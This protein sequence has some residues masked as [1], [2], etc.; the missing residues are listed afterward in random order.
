MS[1]PGDWRESGSVDGAVCEDRIKDGDH[2]RHL[3]IQVFLADVLNA[4]LTAPSCPLGLSDLRVPDYGLGN[5]SQFDF[6]VPG[7]CS[8][9]FQEDVVVDTVLGGELD[10]V[11]V[12][13]HLVLVVPLSRI[14]TPFSATVV[15]GA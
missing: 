9:G 10:D 2:L 5:G 13:R 6:A 14:V 7:D 15:S 1:R 8:R 3:V 11:D 12:V 4:F